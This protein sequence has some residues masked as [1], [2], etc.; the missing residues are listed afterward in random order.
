MVVVRYGYD[1]VKATLYEQ[2][3][4]VKASFLCYFRALMLRALML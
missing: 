4:L 2:Q 3:H 1:K